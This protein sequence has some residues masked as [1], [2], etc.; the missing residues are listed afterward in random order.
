MAHC[1]AAEPCDDTNSLPSYVVLKTLN[2]DGDVQTCSLLQCCKTCILKVVGSRYALDSLL[3]DQHTEMLFYLLMH[4]SGSVAK[5][6]F[7]RRCANL[8]FAAVLQH[9]ESATIAL[10]TR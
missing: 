5:P 10:C 6:A 2:S 4:T 7:R 9:T 1:S 3:F 8:H